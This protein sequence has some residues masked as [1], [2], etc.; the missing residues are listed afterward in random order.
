MAVRSLTGSIVCRDFQTSDRWL[1][2]S[3]ASF[4]IDVVAES[5]KQPVLVFF[6]SAEPLAHAETAA[7]LKNA[8]E[9]ASKKVKL[10]LLHMDE[11]PHIAAGLGIQ[12]SPA[13]TCFIGGR[14]VDGFMGDLPER[15]IV[16]LIERLIGELQLPSAAIIAEQEP[17]T[18]AADDARVAEL[19]LVLDKVPD[20]LEA[21]FQLALALNDSGRRE[22]AADILLALMRSDRSWGDDGAR[23]QLISFF[24]QWGHLDPTTIAS[25]RKLS[26]VLFS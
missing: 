3:A 7:S 26:A 11:A 10:M 13:V 21:R 22:S 25:R 8:V 17:S 6:C 9:G 14:P 18:V 19:M 15:Q 12:S 4:Q 20:N 1:V 16:T 5:Q 2:T 23:K 24:D